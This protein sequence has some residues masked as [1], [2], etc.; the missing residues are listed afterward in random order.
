MSRAGWGSQCLRASAAAAPVRRPVP[1]SRARAR[2]MHAQSGAL[3]GRTIPLVATRQ[4]VAA[5]AATTAP[6]ADPRVTRRNIART[7]GSVSRNV[8]NSSGKTSFAARPDTTPRPTSRRS[9]AAAAESAGT[10]SRAQ[11]LDLVVVVEH[12]AAEA[13][14][15]EI[16]EQQVAGEDVDRGELADRVAVLAIACSRCASSA[17]SRKRLSGVIRRSMYRCRTTIM[18]PSCSISDGATA[19]ELRDAAPARSARAETRRRSTRAMS[20]MRPTRSWCLTSAYFS[21]TLSRVGVLRRRRSCRGS[22]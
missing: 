3:R 4:P 19:V 12:D 17:A 18:S 5:S 2:R 9:P 1:E 21:L 16:L 8:A 22:P 14:H 20:A 15:A 7:S 6:R 13:R 10:G 11:V